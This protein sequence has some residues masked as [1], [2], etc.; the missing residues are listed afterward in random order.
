MQRLDSEEFKHI[1][2]RAIGAEK[3]SVAFPAFR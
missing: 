3:A 2:A 1:L